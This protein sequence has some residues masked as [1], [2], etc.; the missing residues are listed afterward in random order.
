MD[1]ADRMFTR[2]LGR[3]LGLA[4]AVAAIG[5]AQPAWSQTVDPDA[6]I[7]NCNGKRGVGQA[8]SNTAKQSMQRRGI[9]PEMI[10]K[11][12]AQ[13]KKVLDLPA[14]AK[15]SWIDIARILG[16]PEGSKL[17]AGTRDPTYC[18]QNPKPS[19]CGDFGGGGAAVSYGCEEVEY[20]TDPQG[21]FVTKSIDLPNPA[22]IVYKQSPLFY[23]P[24]TDNLLNTNAPLS[25]IKVGLHMYNNLQNQNQRYAPM[26]IKKFSNNSYQVFASYPAYYSGGTLVKYGAIY[27]PN[28]I[29]S[30]GIWPSETPPGT[31]CSQ[32]IQVG[33]GKDHWKGCA[34]PPAAWSLPGSG[35]IPFAQLGDWSKGNMDSALCPLSNDLIQW[36][37]DH[38]YMEAEKL[39]NYDGAPY[40]KVEPQDV[41]NGGEQPTIRE[42]G[43]VDKL[44]SPNDT[45]GTPTPTPTTEPT[46]TPSNGPDWTDPGTQ[47]PNPQAGD[48]ELLVES[49][50]NWFPDLPK[51]QINLGNSACP[52]YK[53]DFYGHE[54]V[55]DSHCPFIEQNRAIISALMLVLF[56]IAAAIIV[57]RA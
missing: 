42:T 28:G 17:G 19:E 55:L 44:P 9:V 40:Q 57:L 11:T 7:Y 24:Y 29:N 46:S 10:D 32:G 1:G 31:E 36:L 3:L 13:M 48:S 5:I 25:A 37:A 21:N 39:P 34:A 53:A 8:V 56:T 27:A 2:V 54:L 41:R 20:L 6:C 49:A 47:A 23:A 18:S 14:F 26:Y 33:V 4:I 12:L 35:P 43:T 50:F 52:V 38:I 30:V 15:N 16:Y 51:I 22:P 45:P